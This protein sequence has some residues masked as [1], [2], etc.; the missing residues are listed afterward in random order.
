MIDR[1]ATLVKRITELCQAGLK[2]CHCIKEFHLR[3]IRTLDRWKTLAFE[4]PWMADPSHNP[5][6]GNIFILSL[7]H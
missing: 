1:L 6:E 4:Y 3:W 5:S 7:H 2:A